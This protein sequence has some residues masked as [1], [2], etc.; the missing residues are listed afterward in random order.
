[1]RRYGT[2]LGLSVCAVLTALGPSLL[3]LSAWGQVVWAA[4]SS[5]SP[6]SIQEMIDEARSA[7]LDGRNDDHLFWTREALRSAP[8]NPAAHWLAG[9][10]QVDGR[11]T[12]VEAAPSAM[13]GDKNYQ[14][15]LRIRSKYTA[16]ARDQSRLADWCA[17]HRL[18]DQARAHFSRVV[19]LD[20]N[21]AAAWK[22]LGYKRVGGQWRTA[23]EIEQA[24][25]RQKQV[26]SDLTQWR[27]KVLKLRSAL[28]S[29][30]DVRRESARQQL[31]A[32]RDPAAIPALEIALAS[33]GE[34]AAVSA[35]DA[36]GKIPG[37][38][39]S[40]SLARLAA[41]SPWIDPRQR[42]TTELKSRPLVE[43]VPAMLTAMIAPVEFRDEVYYG[44]SRATKRGDSSRREANPLT[45]DRLL[46]RQVL[47][48]ETPSAR[49]ERAFDTPFSLRGDPA[50]VQ[51]ISEMM[52]RSNGLTRF[53]QAQL[54]AENSR[55]TEFNR[56]IAE[57]LSAVSGQQL[58][59]SAK[60]WWDWWDSYNDVYR[61]PKPV[62]QTV[63]PKYVPV[64]ASPPPSPVA[65]VY[66]ISQWRWG[67][68]FAAGT[69]IWTLE[70]PKPVERVVVGDLVLSQNAQ[71]GALAYKPVLRAAKRPPAKL[72]TVTVGQDVLRCTGGHPFWVPG[73]GWVHARRLDTPAFLH[74][75]TG[76]AE[77]A[78]VRPG[79]TEKTFNL[80]VAD[81]HSYFVGREKI[82]VH[83]VTPMTPTTTDVPGLKSP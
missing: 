3:I 42:A 6:I 26:R 33:S 66:R 59:N 47:S 17:A 28:S 69:A 77:A 75:L 61:E 15:Y 68:C 34:T 24:R 65:Q 71:T 5:D 20:P 82:L 72:V 25:D 46:H 14:E 22:R 27:P 52:L 36:I 31:L 12:S 60:A 58:G 21:N 50:I 11:W 62:Q 4:S 76:T 55:S 73:H 32:I 48:R 40:L 81:F 18:D 51:M 9:E 53:Q 45:A 63:E 43:F 1:M 35:V 8:A 67:E 37:Q 44:N 7:E 64:V 74:A 70:G 57:V 19:E 10:V 54:D 16:T 78:S 39:A 29:S 2:G 49:Q 13:I 79:V 80:E 38:D 41:F 23:E 30:D 83:D 56:P